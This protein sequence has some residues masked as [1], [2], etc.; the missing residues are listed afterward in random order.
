MSI[1]LV[2]RPEGLR[3]PRSTPRFSSAVTTTGVA[4]VLT[5]LLLVGVLRVVPAAAFSTPAAPTAF[6]DASYGAPVAAPVVL[7]TIRV[8]ASR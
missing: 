2:P 3:M 5:A 6:Q 7:P 1:H 8:V 4:G